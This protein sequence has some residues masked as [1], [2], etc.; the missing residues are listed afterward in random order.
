[1]RNWCIDFRVNNN[2]LL[3]NDTGSTTKMSVITYAV[4]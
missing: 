4:Q 1:M 3:G 2:V